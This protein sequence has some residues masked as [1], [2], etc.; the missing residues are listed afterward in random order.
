VWTQIAQTFIEKRIEKTYPNAFFPSCE[1]NK[2]FDGGD[3]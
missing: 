2:P 1:A 3:F